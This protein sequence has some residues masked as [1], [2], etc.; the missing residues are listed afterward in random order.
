MLDFT[1][2]VVATLIFIAIPSYFLSSFSIFRG[3]S[4]IERLYFGFILNTAI[5][6]VVGFILSCFKMFMSFS[7]L[8]FLILYNLLSIIIIRY[9]TGGT[10]NRK[11]VLIPTIK[12]GINKTSIILISIFI[13]TMLICYVY[14]QLSPTPIGY[15]RGQHFGRSV[16]LITHH[17]LETT[18]PGTNYNPFYFQGAN[19]ILSAFVI[20]TTAFSKQTLTTQIQDFSLLIG[21]SRMFKFYFAFLISMNVF[22]IYFISNHIYKNKK[23]SMLSL[24]IFV[25]LCG[26]GIANVGSIGTILGFLF[27]S[28]F[29]I[30]FD[31]WITG[32]G[33]LKKFDYAFLFLII[34]ATILTHIISA[35]FLMLLSIFIL[36][37]KIT[38]KEMEINNIPKIFL[39]IL[40]CYLFHLIF[41][42]IFSPQLLNGILE[43]VFRKLTYE[44]SLTGFLPNVIS[45]EGYFT[46]NL[47][48]LSNIGIILLLAS[49]FSVI[50]FLF[51]MKYKHSMTIP[52]TISSLL[53][54]SVPIL[55]FVKPM[56][57]LVFPI[58]IFGG[59][60]LFH[61]L[62]SVEK[63]NIQILCI[64]LIYVVGVIFS[65]NNIFSYG[66]DKLYYDFDA[67]EE[68]YNLSVWFNEELDSSYVILF[69]GS[70]ALA[71]LINSLSNNKI[72]FAEPRYPDIPSYGETSKLYK[73]YPTNV[74]VFDFS[75]ISN[76]ERRDIINKYNISV[77]VEKNSIKSDIESLKSYYS[78]KVYNP[79]PSYW[80]ILLS[81]KGNKNENTT[82]K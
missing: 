14:I 41:L 50:G 63:H 54:V 33:N 61:T 19:L 44:S 12:K 38:K 26:F 24:L 7:L 27:L 36:S 29:F 22:A 57:Y 21:L 48:V 70:G 47:N 79:T 81:D 39:F 37:W 46:K 40:F 80:V 9:F 72:L 6:I 62:K 43:E 53:F 20:L 66:I 68:A 71:Y 69:P 10:R 35:V 67:Y 55:P 56:N 64:V 82:D 59:L 8:V 49:C 65:I 51:D 3:R 4:M 25:S 45:N 11:T 18:H 5:F 52:L 73:I 74:G 78:I 15:D 28:I 23:L 31:V 42:Y 77:I 17:T 2:G 34:E 58:S 16:Y 60:G 32:N 30:Y 13:L 75:G 1:I 76:I